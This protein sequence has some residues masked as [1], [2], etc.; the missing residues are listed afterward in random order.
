MDQVIIKKQWF[1]KSSNGK[2]EDNYIVDK[3]E[4]GSGSYGRVFLAKIK[5]TQIERAIKVIP[6]SKV[7]NPEKFKREIDIMRNL[8]HPNIIKLYETFED[9]RN[10]YLVMEL[11]TGGELFDKI[12]EKGHFSEKE[13]QQIFLQIIQAI[14][15]CH[16]NDICHRD[17][18]PE[19]FLLLDKSADAPIKVI[20]FGLS[21]VFHDDKEGNIQMTTKAGTP[22]YISPEILS[23]Q[24]DELCDIWS[25][26]VILYILLTGIPP[27]NGRTDAEI[28][29]AVKKGVFDV[30]IPAF[31]GVSEEVKDLLHKML[32]K[33]NV[34][35]NAEQV[36][37]HPWVLHTEIPHSNLTLNFATL[38]G[39]SASTKVKR[40]FL[41]FMASQMSE[42]EIR[43]L[44]KLFKELDKNGDGVLTI[45]EIKQGIQG[46]NSENQQE[47][48]NVLKAVDTDASGTINYTEFLAATMDKALYMKKEKLVQAFKAFDTDGS[49]KI[50]KQ[51]IKNVLGQN[52]PAKDQLFDQLIKEV[53]ENG[54]GEIDYLEFVTLMDKMEKL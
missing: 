52:D 32:C 5:D 49:G 23:G 51:E 54:D 36:L 20:D 18:K 25:S 19:N 33:P 28:M 2:L 47:V 43:E 30:S 15:H 11:C 29:A 34:R 1:I 31:N 38:K 21:A 7:R 9:S 40:V 4:L 41:S 17:L 22:Y 24:Y 13:A 39:F 53:D 16:K 46:L 8:D 42:S 14:N 27:F 10:V 48:L 45:E 26:G 6:K 35:L 44:G 37:Q 50:S 12:I 3:K